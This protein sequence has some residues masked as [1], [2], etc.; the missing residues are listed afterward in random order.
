MLADACEE[1]ANASCGASDTI[2][3]TVAEE[4]HGGLNSTLLVPQSNH[5]SNLVQDVEDS[6]SDSESGKELH[7]SSKTLAPNQASVI[8]NQESRDINRFKVIVVLILLAVAVVSSSCVVVFIKKAEQD[9]FEE[10][11]HDDALKVLESVRNSIDNT[12][13]PLDNLA[14]A[15]VSH[16]NARNEEWPYVTIDDFAVRVAKILPLTDAIWITVLPVVTPEKR[17]QWENYSRSHDDWVVKSFAI[18]DTWELYYG[19]KNLTFD[20]EAAAEINGNFGILEANT[21]FV[22]VVNGL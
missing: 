20:A 8:G 15:L 4:I 10:R 5:I 19:P 9:Q 11:F 21:R 6:V 12:L 22:L 14:V 1:V 3:A 7:E 13:M 16:A 18:Q 17:Q 2:E